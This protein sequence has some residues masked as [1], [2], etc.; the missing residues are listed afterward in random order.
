MWLGGCPVEMVADNGSLIRI[1]SLPNKKLQPR[2]RNIITNRQETYRRINICLQLVSFHNHITMITFISFLTFITI[3]F[4]MVKNRRKYTKLPPGPAKI[5]VIGNLHQLGGLPHRSL[6]QLSKTHG[7]LMFLQLGTVPALV[8][9]SAN[10]A[11]QIF[12]NHD[13][14]FS[15]RPPLYAI[16]KIS[17]NFSSVSTAPYGDLWREARKILVLELMTA[18]RVES[19][20]HVR[21]EE[22]DR[23]IDRIATSV[24][25]PVDLSSLVFAL[26]NNIVSRAAFGS[27]NDVVEGRSFQEVFHETQHMSAEFNVAD[28]FPGLG[29]INRMNG[30]D[31]RIDENFRELDGFFNKVIQDHRDRDRTVG[32]SEN[33]D[34]IDVL[35]RVQKDSS[36]TIPLTDEQ[37]IKGVLLVSLFN[38]LF[39]FIFYAISIHLCVV[40]S[41]N[42]YIYILYINLL[43]DP[44]LLTYTLI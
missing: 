19:F 26:S 12:K 13:L 37:L 18:K 15:G 42:I 5:P 8:V 10:R 31:R 9:S 3:L 36:Q 43:Y 7:D 35:L 22:V 14:V 44:I 41:I 30:V 25:D 21:A 4:I 20:R 27:A 40:L 23:M 1:S 11:R 6:Q 2:K 34:I 33:E 24:G 16:R 28:Y 39:F 38:S 32:D 17:Y 29:W